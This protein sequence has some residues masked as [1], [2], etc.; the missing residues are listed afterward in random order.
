LWQKKNAP[1]K[2]GLTITA[3]KRSPGIG[4][5]VSRKVSFLYKGEREFK[6]AMSSLGK[7]GKTLGKKRMELSRVY[8]EGKKKFYREQ[9]LRKKSIRKEEHKKKAGLVDRKKLS[10]LI[11]RRPSEEKR[12]IRTL[13]KRKEKTGRRAREKKKGENIHAVEKKKELGDAWKGGGE[14][15]RISLGEKCGWGKSFRKK[16]RGDKRRRIAV[17]RDA[18]ISSEE[19]AGKTPASAVGK[20]D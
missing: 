19:K 10:S 11:W 18:S 17:T 4:S 2:I 5:K 16:V 13:G 20:G 9:P 15:S 6:K 3:Q 12:S 8:H 7:R 1:H 14:R